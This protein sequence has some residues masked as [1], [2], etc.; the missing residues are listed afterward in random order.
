[1]LSLFRG[2]GLSQAIV[3]GIAFSVIIVF[4]LEFRAGRSGPAAKIKKECAV[5]L[6][7]ECV[8]GKDYFAE[9]YLLTRGLEPRAARALGLRKKAL[10]GIA[11]RE[12]LVA[13]AA[14]LGISIS[15]AKIDDELASG[16]AHLSIP[17]EGSAQLSYQLGL[18]RREGRGCEPGAETMVRQLRVRRTPSDPFDY[19]L[20][21]REVVVLTNRG[22]KEFKKMQQRELTAARMR[23]LVRERVR[24]PDA[25]AFLLYQRDRSKVVTRSVVL[26]RDWFAKYAVDLS[27]A[28]VNKWATDNKAQ[29]DSAWESEKA[30]FPA[31]C[32]FVRE[33]L[34]ESAPGATD[35][36]K[37]E[38]RKKLE[39]ARERIGKE[40][41]E[42][43]ARQ[44]GE[45]PNAVS[46]G[47]LGC[48]GP[49]YGTGGE[50]LAKA[51]ANL[52]AG[53]LSQ[54][55]E[56]PRGFHLLEVREKPSADATEARARDYIARKLYVRFAADDKV[57]AFGTE[58]IRRAK[59][60]EKL[61]DALNATLA[62]YAPARKDKSESPALDATDRP[63]LEISAPFSASGN[64]LPDVEPREPL[65]ARAFELQ[66]VDD[67]YQTP[68]LTAD[69]AVVMQLKE[70]NPTTREEFDKDKDAVLESLREAKADEAL[71]RY[72]TDLRRKAGD[73]LKVDASFGQEQKTDRND[74]E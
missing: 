43:V 45:G 46:G 2:G 41:F 70:K 24:V 23:A 20:Y 62:S 58:L 13:D 33:I 53:E 56:T 29:V 42:S 44:V 66:N 57:K 61:E 28:A 39:L 47:E 14:R 72:V 38:L 22:P 69:G 8:D 50:E 63:K 60:G 25:E 6:G 35:E 65:A 52:K 15:E 48:I 51:A 64:P 68:I 1:M 9:Y 37:A 3:G 7:S 67:V 55:I 21:E 59:A 27:T 73:K 49:S 12:L 40:S 11:E 36:E 18:C 19:K 54:V 34:L 17:V 74:D 71:V 32:P 10:D 31:G 4:A 26:H 5:E 30:N 16:R